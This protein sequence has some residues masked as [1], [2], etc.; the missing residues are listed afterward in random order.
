MI[1]LSF[2][3][4]PNDTFMFDALIHNKIDTEGL[5]FDVSY[6][7]I[8]TLNLNA[9]AVRADVTKLSTAALTGVLDNYQVL[10]AGS[11]VGFGVGPLLISHKPV[12]N[13]ESEIATMRI[14][15]P[16]KN[17]T[18]RFLL[19]LA[20]PLLNEP[21]E[22]IFSAIEEAVLSGQIDAGLI[23]HES[24]FTYEIRGLVKLIDLGE[25]WETKTGLPIPL[26]G[27]AIRRSFDQGLKEKVD[28]VLARSVDFAF[29]NPN[30]ALTFIR[31]HAQEMDD[32]VMYKHIE[33]YVNKYSLDLGADGKLAFE[34][35]FEEA[36]KAGLMPNTSPQIFVGQPVIH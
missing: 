16:G 32:A 7:D 5:K 31:S 25:Y 8:Q 15:I 19:K 14:G 34:R 30:S 26:A 2:S 28:R 33:L 17:T 35:F 4:C 22:M 10:N 27:I 24:R 12:S 23:I 3:P 29:K 21:I 1:R 9:F 11:A 20:Y 36:R 13:L 6:E 18:A